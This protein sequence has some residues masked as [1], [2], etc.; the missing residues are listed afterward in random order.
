MSDFNEIGISLLKDGAAVYKFKDQYKA[1]DR[2]GQIKDC[3]VAV[4][5]DETT[6]TT[7]YEFAISWNSMIGKEMNYNTDHLILLRLHVSRGQNCNPNLHNAVPWRV[8]RHRLSRRD[9]SAP[10][11]M[12][13]K[14]MKTVYMH[15]AFRIIPKMVLRMVG[16]C[17]QKW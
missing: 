3:E 6:K 9:Q 10:R 17:H 4:V 5:R 2:I 1:Q 14:A 16:L 7:N 15:R 13:M 11:H 8:P 12:P